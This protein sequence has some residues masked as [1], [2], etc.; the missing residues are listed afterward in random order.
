[1]A[2]ENAVG[3]VAAQREAA[4]RKRLEAGKNRGATLDSC[5]AQYQVALPYGFRLLCNVPERFS[6]VVT[7][8][9]LF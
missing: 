9:K 6:L 1:M 5:L 3:A 4:L 2:R 7:A 8:A